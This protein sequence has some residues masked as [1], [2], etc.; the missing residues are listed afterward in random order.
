VSLDVPPP[1]AGEELLPSPAG[2]TTLTGAAWCGF[3]FT[4]RRTTGADFAD[5]VTE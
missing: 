4:V 3:T 5:R 2:A 1:G